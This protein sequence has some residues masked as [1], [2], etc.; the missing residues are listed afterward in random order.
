MNL[1]LSYLVG[2]RKKVICLI[3]FIMIIVA[4]CF[5][6]IGIVDNIGPR[7][8][9]SRQISRDRNMFIADYSWNYES[10]SD[11]TI[12]SL[13]EI[14]DAFLEYGYYEPSFKNYVRLLNCSANF[15]VRFNHTND[16]IQLANF[17]SYNDT[18]T[19]S[20]MDTCVLDTI[21]TYLVSSPRLVR[22]GVKSVDVEF[23][24]DV[25][26]LGVFTFVRK[27]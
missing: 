25:K 12:D 5:F 11:I 10:Y 3:F 15:I 24:D 18:I 9:F 17:Y 13:I 16:D 19:I 26:R 27:K 22:F 21:K 14:K 6:D 7:F 23:E 8:S 20:Y 4:L 1:L 2:R